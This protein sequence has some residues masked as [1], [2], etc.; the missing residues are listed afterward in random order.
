MAPDFTMES[1]G[2]LTTLNTV[3]GAGI[4]E[5]ILAVADTITRIT[6]VI[7]IIMVGGTGIMTV[8]T[9]G[10]AKGIIVAV[11]KGAMVAVD[12]VVAIAVD[13]AV[14]ITKNEW[15]CGH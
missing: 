4:I 14:D 11:I 8:I 3:T 5:T 6:V 12:T 9:E 15:C 1:G 7:A 13:T 2:L 10:I